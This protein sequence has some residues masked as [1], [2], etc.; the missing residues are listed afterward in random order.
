M[1]EQ[2]RAQFQSIQRQVNGSKCIFLDGPAG[3]QVPDQVIDSISNY[4]KTSNANLHGTFIT[5]QET[6]QLM[7]DTRSLVAK[8]LGAQGGHNIS[9]GSNM[10]TLNYSL[11]RAIGRYLQP[12][13]EILITQLDHEANRGPWLSLEAEGVTIKEVKIK[14]NGTLDY[15]DL[16]EKINEYTKLVCV[17]W[18]SNI[19]GAVNDIKL[20]RKLS[21][22]VGA[23]LLVDAVHYAP[24]FRINVQDM[25]IDFLLCSAYKFYGPHVGLLYAKTGLLDR[26]PTDRLR[27]AYQHAPYSIE[28]GT[29]NHAAIAGVKSAIEFIAAHG[30]GRS[31]QSQL[32]SALKLIGTH[33]LKLA[34]KLYK[35]LKSNP[36]IKIVGPGFKKGFRAPTISFLHQNHDAL[37]ICQHLAKHNIFA[38]A[39]HFYALRA[40]EVLGLVEKGGVTR[41]GISAYTTEHEVNKTLKVVNSLS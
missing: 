30:R 2:F 19:S 4:Y 8:F 5:T 37:S 9:F 29:F 17:G 26:L 20:I 23:W 38:W 21:R 27:T 34:K 18:S 13:D 15:S 1:N 41:M 22:N 16:K 25:D 32:D 11:A 39:G 31:I 28:T 3:T 36:K 35:G 10:T 6:D 12:G 40:S 14:K 33:E 24:H 7:S